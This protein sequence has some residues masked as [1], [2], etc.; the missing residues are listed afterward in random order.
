ML[1]AGA[2]NQA[3]SSK[4]NMKITGLTSVIIGRVSECE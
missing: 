4:S 1:Y 2:E 3:V